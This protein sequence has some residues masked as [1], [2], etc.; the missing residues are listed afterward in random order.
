MTDPRGETHG[1]SGPSAR[2]APTLLSPQP[3]GRRLVKFHKDVPAA[4]A[5]QLLAA[6][7]A[8]VPCGMSMGMAAA[9]VDRAGR[10]L[11]PRRDRRRHAST[12]RRWRGR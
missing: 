6:S 8:A 7:G 3:T 11:R 1:T 12:P 5:A 2:N 10:A 4:R 9:I